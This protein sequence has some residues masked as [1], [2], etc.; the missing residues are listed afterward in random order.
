MTPY[1]FVSICDVD[2]DFRLPSR[3]SLAFAFLVYDAAR[4]WYSIADISEGTLKVGT[5]VAPKCW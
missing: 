5:D 2:I 1:Y 3:C 4:S